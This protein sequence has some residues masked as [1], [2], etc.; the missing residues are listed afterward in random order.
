VLSG[1]LRIPI[2]RTA[3]V[4]DAVTTVV[5]KGAITVDGETAG[6]ADEGAATPHAANMSDCTTRKMAATAAG[7]LRRP[8]RCLM[9][10]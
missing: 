7:P 6:R 4:P 5:L 3:Q 8:S 9:N 1:W 2:G 10:P